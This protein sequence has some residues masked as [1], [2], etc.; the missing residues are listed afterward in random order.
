MRVIPLGVHSAFAV[1]QVEET[2][3]AADARKL[4]AFALSEG[5][6]GRLDADG[7]LAE[8]DKRKRKS[9]LPKWHSNFL[10][11]FDAPGKV[12][13]DVFRLVIDCGGDIRHSLAAVGLSLRDI[14]AWYISHPHSDH[15]GGVEGAALT[16][17]F[18]PNYSKR[19]SLVLADT[20]VT[21]YLCDNGALPAECK[22][23]IMGHPTVLE[24]VWEASAPGLRTIQGVEQVQLSTYF[25]PVTLKSN[26]NYTMRD[27]V[28]EWTYYTI[29]TTHVI[30][31]RDLMPS[32]GLM[33]EDG[34][35]SVFF[36]T[37]TQLLMPPQ[38]RY[39]YDRATTVYMDCET[40]FASGVH[41]HFSE[42]R[43]L[44]VELKRKMWLYHYDADPEPET[45]EF[46]GVLRAGMRHEYQPVKAG[47]AKLKDV[48][49]LESVREAMAARA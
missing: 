33:F 44:P 2:V 24:E 17:L 16:T 46:A 18:N 48:S 11:E 49:Q 35:S 27:G 10:L 12:R 9:Y 41:P 37:D 40:G 39:F 1:G 3:S 31:G 8:V 38:M 19:K 42:L 32:Y 6:R 15:I 28:G 14:D 45:G 5:R 20:P 21:N 34:V 7:I 13:P 23:D 29:V 47:A 30:S 22:P 26:R 36:P 43:R 25:H 4:V